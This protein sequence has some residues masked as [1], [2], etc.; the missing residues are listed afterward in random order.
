M[1]V[2]L[3]EAVQ[4]LVHEEVVHAAGGPQVEGV[5]DGGVEEPH[6]VH[7]AAVV[8]GVAPDQHVAA[9]LNRMSFPVLGVQME[10]SA[11]PPTHPLTH[12]PIDPLTD[13]LIHPLIDP[14]TDP[15]IHPLI[16]PLPKPLI[17]PLID[18]LTDPLIHPLID[19]LPKPLIHPL[20]DPPKLTHPQLTHPPVCVVRRSKVTQVSSEMCSMAARMTCS[21][22]AGTPGPTS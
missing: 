2:S 3:P 12:L 9:R 16:D 13:P 5:H 4:D 21:Q 15:L 20:I 8:V 14:L 1:L 6:G 22:S 7:V 19:P 18:P 10:R 17:H 11:P